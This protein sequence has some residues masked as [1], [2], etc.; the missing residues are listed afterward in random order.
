MAPNFRAHPVGLCDLLGFQRICDWSREEFVEQRGNVRSSPMQQLSLV[1]H[2]QTASNAVYLQ[3]YMLCR[4]MQ[5]CAYRSV[6]YI[7]LYMHLKYHM[8]MPHTM[9][10]LF[11][12]MQCS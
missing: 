10:Q 11:L 4:C 9:D 5:T 3:T 2:Q 6:Q 1:A 7:Y 8:Y 12:S